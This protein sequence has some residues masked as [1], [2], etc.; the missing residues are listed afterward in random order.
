[1]CGISGSIIF[2][3]NFNLRLIQK[4]LNL[5]KNRGPD[6]QSFY[7]NKVNNKSVNLLH[8]RLQIIDLNQRANQPMTIGNYTIVFNGEIYNYRE[9]REKLI[10]KNYKFK[11]N[12]DT[13]VLLN[14][15]IEFGEKCVDYF[16]GMWAFA[17]WN[18]KKKYLFL[19]RDLFGEKPLYYTFI[20]NSFW[21]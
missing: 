15:Y 7:K 5:M 18:N 10:K 1:M 8:S 17:I 3:K 19:S 13:E 2:E 20:Y 6:N 21:F 16:I 9:L 14:A 4:T 12:S 11:T